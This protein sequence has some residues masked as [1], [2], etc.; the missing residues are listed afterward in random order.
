ML[1]SL[2]R[3]LLFAL[4]P[5]QAHDISLDML[6]LL[7]P[8]LPRSRVNKPVQ[9][10]GLEFPNSVGLAAGL[11]K[12]ADYLVSVSSKWAASPRSPSPAIRC[13]AFSGCVVSKA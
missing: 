1:Y 10:M 3:P 13:R 5:E 12:N 8:L 11:D 4:D 6:Q 7:H 2:A 9:L